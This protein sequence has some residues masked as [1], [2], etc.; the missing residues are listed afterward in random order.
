MDF[1]HREE[2]INGIKAQ[3]TLKSIFIV[4]DIMKERIIGR[5]FDSLFSD[6]Y[7][8]CFILN[9][10]SDWHIETEKEK[11]DE[12]DF[13]EEKRVERLKRYEAKEGMESV[14]ALCKAWNYEYED[15]DPKVT[16]FIEIIQTTPEDI[17]EEMKIEAVDLFPDVIQ[18]LGELY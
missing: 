17:T 7:R 15:S 3:C 2:M 4:S 13:L 8:E 6:L 16:R 10:L 18:E 14:T 11:A 5:S 1:E 9:I 12:R